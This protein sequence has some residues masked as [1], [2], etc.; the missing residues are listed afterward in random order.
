MDLSGT[1]TDV[2]HPEQSAAARFHKGDK[3]VV[4]LP[5]SHALATGTGAL[6]EYIAV[7]AKYAVAKPERVAFAD[8][9]GCLLTGMTAAQMVREAGVG[10]GDRVLVNA[11]SGGIGTMVVQMVRRVVGE[12]GYVVGVCSGRNAQLVR[13]LGADEVVDYTEHQRLPDHLAARFSAAP[14]DAV[15][16]TLGFQAIYLGCPAYLV[17]GG[18]YSSVGIKP[19]SF[20]VP[21]FLRAVVQMKLNE[22]WPVSTWLGGVGRL[23]KGVSMMAPT[24]ADRENIVAM[25][26]RGDV[27]VVRDSIWPLEE[28]DRAYEKLGTRHA[29]GKVLVRVDAKVG[30]DEC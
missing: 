15:I 4:M 29:R 25:L 28:A 22:W 18:V 6:A 19:P 13:D 27:E 17:P 10:P 30:D 14:F 12:Q 21:D 1:V 2:W 3:V 5:A 9:A 8:A 24:L 23:W 20:G 11:A 7:P 26:G 16:D